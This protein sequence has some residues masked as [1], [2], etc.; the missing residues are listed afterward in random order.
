MLKFALRPLVAALRDPRW[1]LAIAGVV[2]PGLVLAAPSGGQ[3][4]GG[5]ATIGGT[6][7]NVVVNQ[8][9]NSAIINW[10]QF[11][12]GGNEYVVFNQPSA[13]AAVL[14]RV[15]GGSPSEILGNISANGRVFIIN[16]SGVMFGQGAK[17]DVGG[18]VASTLNLSDSD[19]MQ[20]R[21]VMAGAP[22]N[23]ASVS[24]A[25]RITAADGG[26]VVL[27]GGKVSNSGLVQARLG[28]V[29]LASGS[30]LTL[31]LDDQGLVDFSVDAAALSA[32]AGVENIGSVIA[33]GGSVVMSAQTARGLVGSAV[34]NR[35]T[36]QAR[37]IGEHEGS[38][39]LMAEGGDIRQDGLIDASGA[40]G[41]NA[42]KVR[43]EGDGDIL[44]SGRSRIVAT[45]DSGGDVRAIATGT[46]TYAK[47]AKLDVSRQAGSGAGGFVELSGHGHLTVEDVVQLGRG[48]H[49][50]YDPTNFTIGTTDG[51]DS[52]SEATLESQLRQ[53]SEGGTVTIAADRSI[54]MA[55][56]GDNVLDGTNSQSGL[57]G[58][59]DLQ[60]TGTGSDTF[61]RFDD[62]NDQIKVDGPLSMVNGSYG[63]TINVGSLVSG[64]DV[65]ITSYGNV[66]TRAVTA[67]NGVIDIETF[68][69]SSG[70]SSARNISTGALSATNGSVSL[71]SDNG[72]VTTGN[73][74]STN[75]DAY[76]DVYAGGGNIRTGNVTVTTN[77]STLSAGEGGFIFADANIYMN[78]TGSIDAGNL[79]ATANG[80]GTSSTPTYLV[81]G[82]SLTANSE[83][84]GT[85]THIVTGNISTSAVAGSGTP[86]AFSEAGVHLANGGIGNEGGEEGEDEFLLPGGSITTGTITA[87][88]TGGSQS[89]ACQ[90]QTCAAGTAAAVVTIDA[91]GNVTTQALTT[92]AN[93][94]Q[95][96]D[97]ATIIISAAGDAD[98]NVASVS[99]TGDATQLLI[100]ARSTDDV[101]PPPTSPGGLVAPVPRAAGDEGNITLGRIQGASSIILRASDNLSIDA[102]NNNAIL[103]S[104]ASTV[105]QAGDDLTL[106]G[107]S[108]ILSG[109]IDADRLIIET[110]QEVVSTGSAFIDVGGIS[111]QASRIDLRTAFISVGNESMDLGKDPGLLSKVPQALRPGTAGPNAAFVA[112]QGVQLGQMSIEGGYLFVKAPSVSAVSISAEEDIF[113]N[114]R[115]FSE[116]AAFSVPANGGLLPGSGVTYALG[117]TGY[118]GDITVTRQSAITL[119]APDKELSDTNYLFLTQ[120]RVNGKNLLS[121]FTSGQVLV[122]EGDAGPEEPQEPEPEPMEQAEVAQT[123]ISQMEVFSTDGVSGIEV[124]DAS[125]VEEVTD[126]PDE[127]LECR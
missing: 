17:V 22:G 50:L 37:S 105:L 33:D 122:L 69:P 55:N 111:V 104:G 117:G 89:P 124:A 15:I 110:T 9:S 121:E 43:I 77:A 31:G 86:T 107:R 125:L 98:V 119:A 97:L 7:G 36:V 26:F 11:S 90:Q 70:G 84:T 66:T 100:S 39:Y 60:I 96:G 20:G 87:S 76:V 65:F 14:N 106:K 16:P 13:S 85:N 27:A 95:T 120:G 42:G 102:G 74:T 112:S 68:S 6:G 103:P 3:V 61:I 12:V 35:G 109:S 52:I 80:D 83:G 71:Y 53:T 32:A 81:A 44:L 41:T 56:L 94:P 25:G 38:I 115:P 92:S 40:V 99:M 127:T 58:G 67:S 75:G 88:A 51:Q 79:S 29:A 34:N 2:A 23:S 82:V 64:R 1:S 57:G 73:I 93:G 91:S 10:Q 123:A 78:A 54:T 126:S 30:Q 63:G 45:G 5:Q 108:L 62:L 24:N 101:E 118:R 18:L 47:G 116:T 48:G 21:Y 46:T 72:G 19:F 4:V 8:A 28:K 113:Y 59:L 49:L 114:Y